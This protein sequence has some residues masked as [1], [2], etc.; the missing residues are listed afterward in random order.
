MNEYA[1]HVQTCLWS[2]DAKETWRSLGV[3]PGCLLPTFTKHVD[4]C[5][6]L[7]TRDFL[8][9]Q[10]V[11]ATVTLFLFVG[12]KS[13][14]W[15]ADRSWSETSAGRFI[16]G[17]YVFAGVLGKTAPAGTLCFLVSARK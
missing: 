17:R 11:Q 3:F 12:R 14:A 4:V 9:L 7:L 15:L 13:P 1:N 6:V 2:S 16:S 8:C 5:Q 10:F